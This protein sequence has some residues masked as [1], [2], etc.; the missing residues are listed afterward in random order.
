M[1]AGTNAQERLIDETPF[2]SSSGDPADVETARD[3]PHFAAR[4]LKMQSFRNF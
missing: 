1:G 4:Q 2:R 3:G